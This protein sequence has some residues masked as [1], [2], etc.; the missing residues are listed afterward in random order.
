[1]E[2][3][4]KRLR[5]NLVIRANNVELHDDSATNDKVV[6]SVSIDKG[7]VETALKE[8]YVFIRENKSLSNEINFLI[9]SEQ[10]KIFI[11]HVD[12][13]D[14]KNN[15]NT[16]AEN[17]LKNEKN[18]DISASLYNIVGT[19]NSLEISV[20]NRENLLE[21]ITFIE[22]IG[23]KVVN[24]VGNLNDQK[25]FFVFD[26]KLEFES[27]SPS[28]VFIQG[29]KFLRAIIPKIFSTS[30]WINFRIVRS[31]SI[32]GIALIATITLATAYF[33]RSPKNEPLIKAEIQIEKALITENTNDE[34][35]EKVLKLLD[36]FLLSQKINFPE[37][38]DK[39][40]IKEVKNSSEPKRDTLPSNLVDKS[41]VSK[42]VYQKSLDLVYADQSEIKIKNPNLQIA[43]RDD[44]SFLTE[45]S[46]DRLLTSISGSR[47]LNDPSINFSNNITLPADTEV[48]YSRPDL[49]LKLPVNEMEIKKLSKA[50]LDIPKNN[51]QENVNKIKNTPPNTLE[52]IG[53]LEKKKFDRMMAN[54]QTNFNEGT[55]ARPRIRPNKYPFEIKEEFARPRVRPDVIEVI[56]AK[57][58]IFSDNQLGQSVKPKI[59]PKF[60]KRIV[61]SAATKKSIVKLAT[62]KNAINKRKLNVLSIY[63]RG[64]EKR[65]IVLFP[66]GQTKLVKVGDTLDGGRVA[67][68]G[69]TEIR[70]IKGGNNLVLKIPQG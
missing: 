27:A 36:V 70:Y 25:R 51:P 69:T 66:T 53:I 67:A 4:L 8:C 13:E 52:A 2:G 55:P 62:Q 29:T 7:D 18:I 63:S 54:F 5:L 3:L 21:A 46:K 32:F 30:S 57:S 11:K 14:Y 9:P 31:V 50:K 35:E 17:F 22:N 24:A 40:V 20:I 15:I 38:Q 12:K 41:L 59:R 45:I 48:T 49:N 1:M 43:V 39:A 33:D 26:T 34:T 47:G 61:A 64:S 16:I 60:R 56:A 65:A 68:I 6:K 37:N 28:R 23:F 44:E 58:Q 10:I 19:E 42:S